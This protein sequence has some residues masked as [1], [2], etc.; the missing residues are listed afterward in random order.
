MTAMVGQHVAALYG[1][2][3]L[4]C[5]VG[6]QGRLC[7]PSL[8]VPEVVGTCAEADRA[9]MRPFQAP[10][11]RGWSG[12]CR[13]APRQAWPGPWRCRR[14]IPSTRSGLKSRGHGQ[15]IVQVG[16]VG[17]RPD[18]AE[19][20]HGAG[21]GEH[22]HPGGVERVGH[23]QDAAGTPA[24]SPVGADGGGPGQLPKRMH[25][26]ALDLDRGVEG[27]H[28][29]ASATARAVAANSSAYSTA[30]IRLLLVGDAL[31]G[32]VE[33]GAVVHARCG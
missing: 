6:D 24:A 2:L 13:A 33:G 4:C 25:G 30:S 22:V 26:R 9:A 10:P 32:D 28:A 12:R 1:Q 14:R 11:R 20:G 5:R 15:Q 16:D 18:S 31:A 19:H 29:A 7:R 27:H 3:V 8:P 23:H 17:L 21:K